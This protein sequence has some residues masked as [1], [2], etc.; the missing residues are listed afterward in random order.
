MVH[1]LAAAD[2]PRVDLTAWTPPQM[3]LV[4][5]DPFGKR[6]EILVLEAMAG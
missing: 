5:N 1:E 4:G 2:L 6:S 3:R